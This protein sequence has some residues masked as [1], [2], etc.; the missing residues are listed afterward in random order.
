MIEKD[1]ET[2]NQIHDEMCSLDIQYLWEQNKGLLLFNKIIWIP[3]SF[4]FFKDIG[5]HETDLS[6]ISFYAFFILASFY[7]FVETVLKFISAN[8]KIKAYKNKSLSMNIID[9]LAKKYEF[10]H[11]MKSPLKIQ[12]INQNIE[13]ISALSN[14]LT[15]V[16]H[17]LKKSVIEEKNKIENI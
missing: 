5:F 10:S 14:S 13:T 6:I 1:I 3:T 7:L 12:N 2:V 11:K 17:I 9:D 15:R 8:K 4:V 16:N